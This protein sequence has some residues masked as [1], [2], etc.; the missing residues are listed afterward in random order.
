MNVENSSCDPLKENIEL[1]IAISHELL[2]YS[3]LG[4]S[5]EDDQKNSDAEKSNKEAEHLVELT[6]KRAEIISAVFN[7]RHAQ[8]L[9]NYSDQLEQLLILNQALVAK[10]ERERN[11]TL[12]RILH[13]RNGKKVANLYASTN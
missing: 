10:Y 12:G 13:I 6:A 8:Q 4:D 7:D 11:Q 2:E 3:W 5:E 1:A 9:L